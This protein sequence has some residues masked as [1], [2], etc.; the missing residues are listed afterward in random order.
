MSSIAET[1]STR[2]SRRVMFQ[3]IA[4]F[5]TFIGL[6]MT[7]ASLGPT[8]LGL[9]EH[10][11][12]NLGQI[13]YLFASR[14]L[15]Y[16]LGSL[17]GGRAYDRLPGH[18]LM[19]VM[20]IAM[21]VLLTLAPITPLLWL[22]IALLF[23]LGIAE[24]TIDVGGN[25]LLVWVH[26]GRVGPFM[27]AMHFFFGLGAFIIPIVIAQAILITNDINWAYWLLALYLLPIGLWFLRLPSPKAPRTITEQTNGI[28]D[29]R[30][31][32][33]IVLFFILYTGAEASF[34][35]WVSA[36]ASE[37]NLTS[38]ARAPYLASVY[39]GFFTVGR[40]IAIPLAT[41]WSPQK[42]LT[43]DLVG[44]LL[45]M[46]LILFFPASLT[47]LV[48]G[49]AI[50]GISMASMFP[51]ML[52][53]A[54]QRMSLSGR[55]TGWFFVG[56]GAGVMFLPWLIGQLFEITGPW[57]TMWIIL[58][59][60]ILMSGVFYVI[61]HYHHGKESSLESRETTSA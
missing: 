30:L 59:D 52:V 11:R 8:L 6:G 50:L 47:M 33:I 21:A 25:T 7:S 45:G 12:S 18:L 35:G 43:W 36:Y 57:I 23:I 27:N 34:G 5:A 26:Q 28:F 9:A 44:C 49:S 41:R 24:G 38:L 10:T 31:A 55:L 22:L 3:T 54:E 14:S 60:L 32:R 61:L 20:L 16:L 17:R 40:L 53:Y 19:A 13:S 15:G 29:P 56:A 48:T 37:L 1:T 39:W 4:Y 42:M 46:V 51:S 2:L 58:A